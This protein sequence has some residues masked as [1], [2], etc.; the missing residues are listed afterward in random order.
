MRFSKDKLQE[1][2]TALNSIIETVYEFEDKYEPN[3]RN[4]HPN[5][6]QSARNLVHY[7]ALRSFNINILQQKLEDLGLPITLESQDNILLSIIS[8]RAIVYSLLDYRF[9]EE[10]EMNGLDTSELGMEAYPE[11]GKGSQFT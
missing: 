1:I 2:I 10:Q 5:Y 7:L 8:L 9:T 11:F 4:V 6:A 3:L